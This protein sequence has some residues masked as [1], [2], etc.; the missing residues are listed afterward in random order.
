MSG[1][2]VDILSYLVSLFCVLAAL[3][4]APA[5]LAVRS[6]LRQM[7]EPG[8]ARA[9]APALVLGLGAGAGGAV[10]LAGTLFGPAA[11][12]TVAALLVLA[13]LAM[14]DLAW[15]WLPLEWCGLLA[16]IGVSEA[17]LSGFFQSALLGAA[18]GGGLLL[19]LRIA[20][21]VLRDVE[22]LGL[23]DVWLAAAIG[24]LVGPDY[25]IWL[26]GAAAAF[27]LLLN[28]AAPGRNVARSGVAFGAHMCVVTPFFFPL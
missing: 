27:G 21:L 20:Y 6:V 1:T 24:T 4:I 3:S 13:L 19:A 12:L 23:G 18:L 16:L 17:M 11:T 14:I 15:R 2:V 7:A 9:R 5:Q 10:F 28:F 22:A 8:C 26:L 25:I